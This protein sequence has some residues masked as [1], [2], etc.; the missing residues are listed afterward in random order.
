MQ[1]GKHRQGILS[2]KSNP[3]P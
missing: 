1:K 3:P 2:P